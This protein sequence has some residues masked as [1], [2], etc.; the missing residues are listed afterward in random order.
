M[1]RPM[2]QNDNNT[3]VAF[4]MLRVSGECLNFLA[5]LL[6]KTKQKWLCETLKEKTYLRFQII[7]YR[8]IVAQETEQ[9]HDIIPINDGSVPPRQILEMFVI[10]NETVSLRIRKTT[11]TLKEINF[12]LNLLLKY[13]KYQTFSSSNRT[14]AISHRAIFNSKTPFGRGIP[15][16]SS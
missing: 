4:I 14:L 6:K 12:F 5:H 3:R 1:L 9:I 15:K 11:I 10:N 7:F 13:K 8:H 2:R 16:S